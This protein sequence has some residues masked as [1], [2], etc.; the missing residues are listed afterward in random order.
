MPTLV[1]WYFWAESLV[2][3]YFIPAVLR[4]VL[5]LHG[6]WLVN[7]AAHMWGNR[8]YDKTINPAENLLVSFG[9]V[10]KDTLCSLLSHH[11]VVANTLT[12]F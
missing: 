2:V 6:T 7:S 4:Y 3:S 1:P 5:M 12:A 10:G 11:T 9:A 8:P